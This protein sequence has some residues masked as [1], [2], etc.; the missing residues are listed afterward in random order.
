MLRPERRFQFLPSICGEAEGCE[1]ARLESSERMLHRQ[2]VVAKLP[3]I[4]F[5]VIKVWQEHNEV[6]RL[7]L[8][9]AFS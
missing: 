6:Y 8:P 1:E 3:R 7:N 9:R 2:E 4:D 5:R